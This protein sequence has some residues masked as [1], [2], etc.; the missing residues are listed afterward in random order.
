MKPQFNSK[1]EYL[2]WRTEWRARYKALGQ[3]IRDQ[4]WKQAANSR[5]C[6]KMPNDNPFWTATD[7]CVSQEEKGGKVPP[8]SPKVRML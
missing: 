3:A 5:I 4:K 2:A 1:D 6:A 7:P 8:I